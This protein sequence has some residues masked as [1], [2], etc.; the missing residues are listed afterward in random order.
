MTF[1]KVSVLLFSDPDW[2]TSIV[3]NVY[4]FLCFWYE[5]VNPLFFDLFVKLD[6]RLFCEKRLWMCWLI[7]LSI[8]FVMAHE[9]LNMISWNIFKMSQLFLDWGTLIIFEVKNRKKFLYFYSFSS[10]YI[11]LLIQKYFSCLKTK[12]RVCFCREN[13]IGIML[14]SILFYHQQQPQHQFCSDNFQLSWLLLI[15]RRFWG[16]WE[17]ISAIL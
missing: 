9:L 15:A 7:L 4:P 1:L 14:S 16:K 5:V 12:F 2:K 11:K 13:K 17:I 8:I 10:S 3:I 6:N